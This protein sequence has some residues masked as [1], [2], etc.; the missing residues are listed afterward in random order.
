MSKR[1]I[2]IHTQEIIPNQDSVFDIPI[3][4]NAKKVDGILFNSYDRL[5]GLKVKSGN[6][7]YRSPITSLDYISRKKQFINYLA[8][9]VI[10]A[11]F[12]S[13]PEQIL[14][15]RNS[16][17]N[18]VLSDFNA[19]IVA[20]N[21]EYFTV[22]KVTELLDKIGKQ[23]INPSKTE[24]SGEEWNAPPE[25]SNVIPVFN[26]EGA[27]N[28]TWYDLNESFRNQIGLRTLSS[29][30]NYDWDK[31]DRSAA[32]HFTGRYK[33]TFTEEALRNWYLKFS[34]V[35]VVDDAS[36]SKFYKTQFFANT[37]NFS[38]AK[39]LDAKVNVKISGATTLVSAYEYFTDTFG[40]PDASWNGFIATNV[41][42]EYEFDPI[43]TAEIVLNQYTQLFQY[44][45]FEKFSFD[46]DES[47]VGEVSV[48]FNSAR[49]IVIRDM[50]VELNNNCVNIHH[51]IIQ[52]NQKE[53]VNSYARV[54]F[55]DM[56]KSVNPFMMK[57][58][59]FYESLD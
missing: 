47:T 4:M 35:M 11:C 31:E 55:K 26:Y 18:S 29:A 24:F 28:V 12:S 36:E 1:K 15:L 23:Y 49:D 8:L 32:L 48:M 59:F 57:I 7:T 34:S 58:Y 5:T 10:D 40:A 56:G 45:K 13:T 52:I 46:W 33:K 44:T 30:S 2:F 37:E 21:H 43:K 9:P 53:Q 19:E 39:Y 38:T 3:P 17:V 16:F 6:K 41:I 51:N 54:V 22:E 25:H 42:Y 20:L 50:P 27:Y 14:S